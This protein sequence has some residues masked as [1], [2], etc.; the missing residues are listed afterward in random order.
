MK[1]Q[2]VAGFCLRLPRSTYTKATDVA[3][4]EGVSLNQ[5]IMLAVAE[6]LVRMESGTEE[7]L[8]LS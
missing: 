6:K 5:F 4:D 2:N 8:I 1:N 7:P 3:K